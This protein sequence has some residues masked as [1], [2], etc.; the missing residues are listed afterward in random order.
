MINHH[1][2]ANMLVEYTSGSL[3]WALSISVAAH[4]Q[5]CPKC[6]NQYQ[7]LCSLGGA[8]LN[9][10]ISESVDETSFSR[11]M[12]RISKT[13]NEIPSANKQRSLDQSSLPAIIKKL[14]RQ[15]IKWKKVSGALKTARLTT[16]QNQY[17]V[18]FHKI[19]R[20]GRVIEHDHRGL[21]VTLVLEG[22]FSDENGVYRCGDFIVR[23]P[24][25]VHR[26]TA[27]QDQDCLCLSV[28]EAPVSVTG[29]IG[30]LINPFLTIRP[31]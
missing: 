1:P 15:K 16:G 5:L 12:D 29:F 7:M 25:Q 6:R 10:V 11:L 4:L 3:S 9:E 31:A 19:G 30:R 28:C 23:E 21:E 26:P 18:A 24:G 2:D 20:G 13:G 14:M 27:T 17:E 22:S 8:C